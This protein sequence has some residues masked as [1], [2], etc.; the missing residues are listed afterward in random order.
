ML[1]LSATRSHLY[2]GAR[3]RIAGG[4]HGP[5]EIEFAD[6]SH[7]AGHLDGPILALGPYVTAAGTRIGPARWRIDREGEIFRVAGS[8]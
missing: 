7:A 4:G 5:A 2:T 3:G 6:G 8:A 1:R